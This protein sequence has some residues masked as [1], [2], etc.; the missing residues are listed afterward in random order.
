MQKYGEYIDTVN[1]GKYKKFVDPGLLEGIKRGK[2]MT[3]VNELID[4][5]QVRDEVKLIMNK[6]HEKYDLLVI[7]TSATLPREAMPYTE[8]YKRRCMKTGKMVNIFDCYHSN[9][10]MTS[11]FNFSHQPAISMPCGYVDTLDGKIPIGV[12]LVGGMDKDNDVLKA[13]FCLEK[14]FKFLKAKL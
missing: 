4:V 6:F 3:G 10:V 9:L 1:E 11:L 5:I 13:A 14:K 8:D 12:Q 2:R 7:P